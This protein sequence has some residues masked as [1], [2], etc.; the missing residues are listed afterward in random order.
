M[1]CRLYARAPRPVRA[2]DEPCAAADEPRRPADDCGTN[3]S[4]WFAPPNRTTDPTG[5]Q[6]GALVGTRVGTSVAAVGERPLQEGTGQP[7]PV[8]RC[9]S[10]G[11]K[12]RSSNR[13]VF[14]RGTILPVCPSRRASSSLAAAQRCLIARPLPPLE[15]LRESSF[16]RDPRSRN[17]ASP[18]VVLRGTVRVLCAMLDDVGRG[19]GCVFDPPVRRRRNRPSFSRHLRSR[20]QANAIG[21][22]DAGCGAMR[23]ATS[24][25][26]VARSKSPASTASL[27]ARRSA[28]SDV[29]GGSALVEILASMRAPGTR[30]NPPGKCIAFSSGRR[31]GG[32]FVDER[33]ARAMLP[34]CATLPLCEPAGRRPRV[35]RSTMRP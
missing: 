15:G 25:G 4:I 17:L 2:T 6:T 29:I 24:S 3:D 10:L 12:R 27:I 21:V 28:A 31:V 16:H 23:R 5:D 8:T 35:S 13:R 34:R 1:E 26:A 20:S 7:D 30:V 11:V 22:I 14:V 19:C 18:L 9:R 32:R 33:R